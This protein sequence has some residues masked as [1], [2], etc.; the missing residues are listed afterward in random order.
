MHGYHNRHI[1]YCDNYN[2]DIRI[3]DYYF[4]D[5]AADNATDVLQYTLQFRIHHMAYLY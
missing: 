5:C 1:R 3:R 2:G 4:C